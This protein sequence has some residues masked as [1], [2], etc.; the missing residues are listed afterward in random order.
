MDDSYRTIKDEA[1]VETKVKGSRFI[2]ETFAAPTVDEATTKLEA[3]CKR[4]FNAT[5]HC[6]AYIVGH[7]NDSVFK[8]SDDGEPNGTA[9]KPIYDI[10]E[11]AGLTDLLC[12]VTRYFGG[13]KLGTGGLVRAYSEA[14][15]AALKA[16]GV[17]TNYLCTGYRF[18]LGFSLYDRWQRILHESGA[19][20]TASDFSDHV[21]IE[22]Q[23]R[24]SRADKL[25]ESFVQL[26]SGKGE[27]EK[28]D[29]D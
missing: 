9:G 10:L 22:V 6:Y 17:K 1:R 24:N 12:V 19:E 16:S 20:I 8:Y 28:I 18:T 29:K 5:H 23:I 4:E 14:A 2:G 11:G 13:T 3:V 25:V 21:T 15:S 26:T 7:D 27:V